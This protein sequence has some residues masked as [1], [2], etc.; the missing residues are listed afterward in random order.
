VKKSV[1]G[2]SGKWGGLDSFTMCC[3]AVRNTGH[4]NDIHLIVTTQVGRLK[5]GVGE[6]INKENSLHCSLQEKKP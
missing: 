2:V 6:R 4:L 3:L 5:T 1:G